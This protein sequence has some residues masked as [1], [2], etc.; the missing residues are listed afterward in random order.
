MSSWPRIKSAREAALAR[1]A[2]QI[3]RTR[4]LVIYCHPVAES[5]AASAHRTVLEAL[6][7]AGHEVTTSISTPNTS[8]R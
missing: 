8:I 2:H 3:R 4:V 7:E 1:D 6:A 5:F